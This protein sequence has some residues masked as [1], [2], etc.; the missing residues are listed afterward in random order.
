MQ[1]WKLP[2][3][4]LISLVL[5]AVPFWAQAPAATPTPQ[6]TPSAP[7]RRG[8][9]A[10]QHRAPG[11]PAQ[12]AHGKAIYAVNCAGC[13]GVDLRGGDLGGP[14]LLR[15]QVALSDEN[16]ELILPVIQGSRPES[17][18]PAIPISQED[19]LAV[20]A[21]IRSVVETLGSQGRPPSIGREA[22]SILVGDAAAGQA[23]FAEKCASC[24]SST[25]DLQGIATR[26]P[27]PKALQTLW[28][29]GGRRRYLR[30][31]A[32]PARRAVTVTITLPSGERIEGLLAHIDDF[33]V[34][35]LFED[36]STRTIR[37]E[38]DVPKVEIH[39]PMQ[40]HRDLWA[41]YTDKDIHDVTAYL[42]TLK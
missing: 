19:G 18:M 5:S 29:A 16:G 2:A 15:S 17:G 38:G 35:V 23:Y 34:T 14:N 26:T 20:A 10:R 32:V 40:A 30:A 22:P 36:G 33:L 8:G 6:S 42:V 41:V 4:V 9:F 7:V 3:A 31:A 37:R 12:I 25:G 28:V 27:D 39:D 1:N 11:D 13:H 21:Y 24:H